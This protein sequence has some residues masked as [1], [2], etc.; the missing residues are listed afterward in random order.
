[1]LF[2]DVKA[3]LKLATP[4]PC[5]K[6][7]NG[8]MSL[9]KEEERRK[10]RQQR[11]ANRH[12]QEKID[13][14]ANGDTVNGDKLTEESLNG[15]LSKRSREVSSVAVDERFSALLARNEDE[16]LQFVAKVNKV[17][18]ELLKKPAP[19]MTFVFC[20]MQSAGKST[21]ME[22]FLNS[23]LNIVQQ[24][25]GTRCPLD[26]TCIHDERLLQAE[27]ELW[28]EELAEGRNGS[29]LTV[30]E[31]FER[32]TQHNKELGEKDTFS[33]KPLHL[34]YRARDVQN[35]RFVDTPGIISNQSTGRDNREDIKTIL[36]SEM[37][38][39]NTKLCV[40]LEPKE[41]ETNPIVDFCDDSLGGRHKWI[42]NATF[43][44]TK[45]D[46]QM[47]DA[48]TGSKANAFFKEFFRNGCF[49][50]LIITPTLDKEDLPSDVL[51]EK[52][53]KLIQDADEYEKDKFER[54]Q[55]GHERF[56]TESPSGDETL[57][58]EVEKR[59]GFA[60]AKKTMREIML[61]DTINRLPEVLASLRKDLEDCNELKRTLTE[62]RNLNDP[63]SMRLIVVN[64][65]YQVQKRVLEYLDGDLEVTI[66]FPEEMQTLDDEIEREEDSD[67]SLRQLNYHSAKEEDWR[68]KIASLEPW[69]Q[70]IQPDQKFFGGKQYQRAVEF[71][72]A[73]MIDSLP[74]PYEL[75]DKVRN[76]TGY[77]SGGLQ[78]ENWERAMVEITRVSLKN[79]SHPGINYLIKHVGSIFR[80]L[81]QVALEDIKMGEKDSTQF[82]L[83]PNGLEGFIVSEFDEMLWEILVTTA[84]QVHVSVDPMYS[85][86][87]PNLPTFYARKLISGNTDN[88]YVRQNDGTFVPVSEK[89]EQEH[90]QGW[91]HTW[92]K[93]ISVVMKNSG[94]AVKEFLQVENKNR[95][96]RK[97]S[98][99]PDE[100]TSMITEE[101]TNIILQ[102][103][104]EYIVALLEFVLVVYKFQLNHYLYNGFKEAM[105]R[106]F[107]NR[108]SRA[109]WSELVRPDATLDL[110]ISELDAQIQGLTES[111]RDVLRMQ[112]TL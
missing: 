53:N 16:L 95:A 107:V 49:P 103:S 104:F 55:E 98:F 70:E 81:F 51:F 3:V 35:M 25:T 46:K 23:V 24:G 18:Q 30:H 85:S 89:A 73:V 76:V 64:M 38:K 32:I 57:S 54:W 92:T 86:I 47:D 96:R 39:P 79:A 111:L 11:I 87:D 33:T 31:V 91:M 27:C 6:Y 15:D 7:A 58:V 17:Y 4:L 63:N 40:L 22:R 60:S 52:R 42:D 110:R 28:G 61:K 41:F 45:F 66:K 9:T 67:W 1:M 26:A 65:L 19:F 74:D 71:F 59:L 100:R 29:N 88:H 94:S 12:L 78:Q 108:I 80:H 75:K 56:R 43:L 77:L 10:K 50:H 5:P 84:D 106:D 112:R 14:E 8:R 101:E 99:L 21:I 97:K 109:N 90:S 68:D 102:R 44:M 13:G 2:A 62:K 36:R 20:G 105:R 72:S 83:I 48:R 93:K 37:K 34:V 82:Q 69:P